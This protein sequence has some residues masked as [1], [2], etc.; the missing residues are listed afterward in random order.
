MTVNEDDKATIAEEYL[1]GT[2]NPRE[3][4]AD[5]RALL[6]Q[7]VGMLIRT[8]EGGLVVP[9]HGGTEKAT[10]MYKTAL[11]AREWLQQVEL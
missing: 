11:R 4:F 1:A 5:E 8:M 6:L 9:V 10:D 7:L 2:N 3:A